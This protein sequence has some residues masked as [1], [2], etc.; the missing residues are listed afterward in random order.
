MGLEQPPQEDA[1]EEA[2]PEAS[3]KLKTIL[4]AEARRKIIICL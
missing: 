4:T 1:Q 2:L 3:Q